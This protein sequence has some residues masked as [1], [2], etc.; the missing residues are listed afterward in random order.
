MEE[1]SDKRARSWCWN[2]QRVSWINM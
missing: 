2:Y 1:L